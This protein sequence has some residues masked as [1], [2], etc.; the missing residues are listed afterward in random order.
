MDVVELPFL[1]ENKINKKIIFSVEGLS[2]EKL[3]GFNN[4][5]NIPAENIAAIR[6]GTYLTRGYIFAIGR[7]YYIE[8]KEYNDKV[9][10]I[11]LNSVYGIKNK[12]YYRLWIDIF[13]KLWTY[14]F[15]NILNY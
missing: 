14:Y 9:H 12:T 4:P 5:V 6:Y 11:K 10:R 1:L 2:I 13:D 8:L 3:S 15:A 7:Q